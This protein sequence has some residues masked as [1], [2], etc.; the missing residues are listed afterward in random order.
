MA[1]VQEDL[2][3]EGA[4]DAETKDLALQVGATPHPCS[5]TLFSTLDITALGLSSCRAPVA[6][7]RYHVGPGQVR[8]CHGSSGC[9]CILLASIAES[10]LN[11]KRS[12][13]ATTSASPS[14]QLRLYKFGLDEHSLLQFGGIVAA[15][16]TGQLWHANMAPVVVCR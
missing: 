10:V 13:A 6:T 4:M 8:V 5:G 9:V 2:L 11:T 12:I 14:T 15:A 7:L 3:G 1:D 16:N